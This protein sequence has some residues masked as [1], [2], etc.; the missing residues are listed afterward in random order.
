ME[1]NKIIFKILQKYEDDMHIGECRQ[2]IT[3]E[4][5][6]E[7]DKYCLALIEAITCGSSSNNEYE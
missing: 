2:K 1:L 3:N 5:E 6:K 4:I 7:V